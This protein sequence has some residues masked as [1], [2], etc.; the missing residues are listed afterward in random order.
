MESRA[1]A[2]DEL[3]PI[4]SSHK[5]RKDSLV[6]N[7]PSSSLA[8]PIVLPLPRPSNKLMRSSSSRQRSKPENLLQL[9]KENAKPPPV[10]CKKTNHSIA[11]SSVQARNASEDLQKSR[12]SLKKSS[13]SPLVYRKS[14]KGKVKELN[15]RSQSSDERYWMSF[16][17]EYLRRKAKPRTFVFVPRNNNNHG[18]LCFHAYNV[19]N[20]ANVDVLAMRLNEEESDQD[21]LEN[22]SKS[23]DLDPFTRNASP[24]NSGETTSF[25]LEK[26]QDFGNLTVGIDGAGYSGKISSYVMRNVENIGVG[27]S[28]I[29]TEVPKDSATEKAHEDSFGVNVVNPRSSQE[30]VDSGNFEST[31]DDSS[32]S[33]S[34]VELSM[35]SASELPNS[36]LVKNFEVF[37]TKRLNGIPSTCETA[38]AAGDVKSPQADSNRIRRK[39]RNPPK[40]FPRATNCSYGWASTTISKGDEEIFTESLVLEEQGSIIRYDSISSA[41]QKLL[42][43]MEC[44]R[45]NRFF[46]IAVPSLHFSILSPL[47]RIKQKGGSLS[48]RSLKGK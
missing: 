26:E 39:I 43:V 10:I 17:S 25:K 19:E 38:P 22:F 27:H 34:C 28:T 6:W 31:D 18:S 1:S 44:V 2:R 14:T 37:G 45:L 3:L 20:K 21:L 24:T 36:S 4:S 48:G 9:R 8:R 23:V 42:I 13:T 32:R 15:K 11:R 40:S 35:N 5:P 47:E 7:Q 12:S 33:L 29:A 30:T 41:K 46:S 16:K